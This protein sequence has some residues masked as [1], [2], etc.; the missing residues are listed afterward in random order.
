[1]VWTAKQ[2]QD[3]KFDNPPAGTYG[4]ICYRVIDLGTQEVKWE[5]DV[6][7]QHKV[8]IGFELDEKMEDGRPYIVGRKFTVSL[9][10]K[11]GL[12]AFLKG[13]RGRDFTP[14]ELNGFSPQKLIGAP[15]ML[16]LVQNGDYVNIASAAK[17]PKGMVAPKMTN[18][19]VFLSLDEFD[20]KVYEG[21]SNS[22]KEQ[23]SRSPEYQ[24]LMKGTPKSSGFDDMPDDIPSDDI[25]F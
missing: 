10:E 15:C 11:S 7:Y 1:M 6:K 22:F 3:R 5:G 13:W 24:A 18:P 20:E 4:A 23:I 21:L 8:Y 2:S 14:E 9:H 25:A 16:S 17:L 12:R 19:S